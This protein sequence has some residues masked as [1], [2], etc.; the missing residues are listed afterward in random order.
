MT[1]EAFRPVILG[2]HNGA[3]VRLQQVA[4]VIDSVED[5][6][7]ASWLF[8]PGSRAARH[9]GFGA[10]AAGQQHARGDRLD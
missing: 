7:S 10:E 1:A 6:H 4:T 2:F 5:N 8:D 9:P 3:P